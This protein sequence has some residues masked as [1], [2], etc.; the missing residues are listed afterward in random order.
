MNLHIAKYGRTIL[1]CD[2]Q[3]LGQIRGLV[4][5]AFYCED[6]WAARL[7]SPVFKNI[8]L[9]EYFVEL[10]KKFSTEYK[11][12]ALDVDIFAQAA[13][14]PADCEQLEELMYKLRRTPHTA[15]TPPSTNHAAVR[16]LLG[17]S[18]Q[19]DGD[20]Q[21]HHLVKM[22]DDRINYGLFLDE[23]TTVLIL[24]RMVEEGRLVEGARVA[25]HIMLQE[26]KTTGPGACLGNL[27]CWRY[28][29]SGRSQP[30]YADDEIPVDE[31][32]DEVIRVRVKGMV[33]NNYNDE[34]FDLRDPNR[35][36]G[37]TFSYLNNQTDDLSK[38]L[39][40]LGFVLE[41]KEDKLLSSGNFKIAKEIADQIAELSSNE[42]VKDFA[43][44]LANFDINVDEE[45]LKL[46]G[47]SLAAHEKG[48]VETQSKLYSEWNKSRDNRLEEEYKILVNKSRKEAIV[49]SK[50]ELAREQEKLFFFEN[51]DRLE[52]EK[53][54]KVQAWVRTFPRR[55]WSQPG[56][57]RKGKYVP[58]P[59]ED[60][61]VARWEKREAKKGPAK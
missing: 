29:S 36:L 26:E 24:D 38:S 53:E 17:A 51:F 16:A 40:A 21:L 3:R 11:G 4:S 54:E 43:A 18:E 6:A 37:K 50:E 30:W 46:C 28:F 55:N 42:K 25:S 56:Y 10:D 15:H 52:Q 35:I 34:H 2:P 58:K 47:E 32:P 13:V 5:Q 57:Y 20:E 31:N 22:L 8:R 14:T 39:Q 61:K 1:R 9:G 60:R 49:Q 7:A 41:G 12:S 44:G 27:A 19:Q 59:G 48:L 33:P 45:L 23:Y